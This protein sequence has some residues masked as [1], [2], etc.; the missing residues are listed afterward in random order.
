MWNRWALCGWV[1]WS[2][3]VC[4]VLDWELGVMA[5]EGYFARALAAGV[6]FVM[7]VIEFT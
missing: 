5:Y 4:G 2:T 1:P 7:F 3:L 6:Y